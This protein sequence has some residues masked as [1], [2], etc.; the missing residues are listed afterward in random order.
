MSYANKNRPS[1]FKEYLSQVGAVN[2][3]KSVIESNTHPHGIVI[4]G[5]PGTGK[6]TLAQL[7]TKATLCE[8]REEHSS[9]ACG[10]CHVC[11]TGEHPNIEYYRITEASSFKDVVSD[12]ISIS[13]SAPAVMTDSIRGDNHRRFIIIDEVQNATRQSLSPFLDSLE[14]ASD[15]TTV[16]LI[17]MDLDKLDAIVRDAIESRC[18]ELSLDTISYTAIADKIFSKHPSCEYEA[19]ILIAKLARGNMRKAWSIYEYFAAQVAEEE[20][21]S[22]LVYKLKFGGLNEKTREGFYSSL[23]NKDWSNTKRIIKD[24]SSNANQETIVKTILEDLVTKDLTEEGIE[25]LSALSIWL[26]SSYKIPIEA[27]FIKFQNKC[28]EYDP[29]LPNLDMSEDAIDESLI[30]VI[31]KGPPKHSLPLEA[32]PK[33]IRE[34]SNNVLD[35]MKAIT[36]KQVVVKSEVPLPEWFKVNSWKE[37]LTWYDKHNG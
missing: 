22:D 11:K 24:F 36:G 18:I 23:S 10:H 26:Q 2:Y 1:T 7:Y 35:Q 31:Q 6:T 19:L 13:K 33:A 21:T 37:L 15:T 3:I 14:F 25:L 9:E 27:V 28:L 8:N 32:T 34:S 16:I 4:N 17:S 30:P 5:K 29:D 12:L 20:I